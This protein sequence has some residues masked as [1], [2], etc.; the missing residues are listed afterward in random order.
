MPYFLHIC[1]MLP[2]PCKYSFTAAS[3]FSAVYVFI[4][5]CVNPA[6]PSFS[7]MLIHIFT[8]SWSAPTSRAASLILI[9][10]L[11]Y[12]RTIFTFSSAPIFCFCGITML[13]LCLTVFFPFTVSHRGSISQS[14]PSGLSAFMGAFTFERS[15]WAGRSPLFRGIPSV[16]PGIRRRRGACRS[17]LSG[18]RGIRMQTC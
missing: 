8:V 10:C 13:P 5:R 17:P 3:F 4:P 7:Y 12:S 14:H 9:F 6:T 15:Q 2:P 1:C 16:L 18:P 11:K